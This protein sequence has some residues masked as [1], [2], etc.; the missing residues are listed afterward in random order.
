MTGP[1]EDALILKALDMLAEHFDTVQILCTR[2]ADDGT[3]DTLQFAHG[4]GN[5][6]ARRGQAR[7]WLIASEERVKHEMRAMLDKE[8]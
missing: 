8:E 3:G 7:E 1:E 5:W 6:C 2:M 4:R